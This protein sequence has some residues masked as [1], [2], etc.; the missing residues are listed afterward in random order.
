MDPALC[1]GRYISYSVNMPL[2]LN[3]GRAKQKMKRAKNQT[4]PKNPPKTRSQNTRGRWNSHSL[5]LQ[6]VKCFFKKTFI[7]SPFKKSRLLIQGETPENSK[8]YNYRNNSNFSTSSSKNI[9]KCLCSFLFLCSF[10][11]KIKC[12]IQLIWEFLAALIF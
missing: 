6:G 9:S 1:G 5:R 4:K 2:S 7:N 3:D 11:C 12:W 10:I 8:L